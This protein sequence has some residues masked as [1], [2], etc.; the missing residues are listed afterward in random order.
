M[1]LAQPTSRCYMAESIVTLKTVFCSCAELHVLFCQR[2][3]K[4]ALRRHSRFRQHREA[5]WHHFFLLGKAPKE[6]HA[7]LTKTLGEH[8]PSYAIFKNCVVQFKRGILS[9]PWTTQNSD[10]PGDYWSNSRANLGRPPDFGYINSWATGYLTRLGWVHH[11]WRFGHAEYLHG[12]DPQMPERR[13][14]T[15][16]V[17]VVWA[18]FGIFSAMRY[19]NDFLSRLVTMDET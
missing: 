4:I 12:M 9:S 15:S 16:T 19:P 11:S 18:T 3:W 10:P 7:I 6:I 17:P 8:A 2:G 1:F 5:S 13:W 14:K